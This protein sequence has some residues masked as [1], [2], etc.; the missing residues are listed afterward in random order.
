MT[1]Q[2]KVPRRGVGRNSAVTIER[3]LNSAEAE[4]G[5][6]G[7]DGAKI[8]D[9]A[10]TAG[11]SKQLIYHYFNGKDDLY[12]ELLLHLARRNMELLCAIDF[13]NLDPLEAARTFFQTLFGIYRANPFSSTITLDQGIHVGAQIR[14]HHDVERLREDFYS[15][16][17]A[18]VERGQSDAQLRPDIDVASMHFLAVVLVT[19]SL[20]LQPMFVR[21]TRRGVGKEQPGSDPTGE[22]FTE[23]FMRAISM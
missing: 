9:I 17:G 8:D 11:V 19:G 10:K 20:T 23:Y 3:I 5:S 2:S 1:D 6:K 18:S 12:S 22:Q 7:L 14:Y 21:Y 4:F 16:F 13:A 15:R